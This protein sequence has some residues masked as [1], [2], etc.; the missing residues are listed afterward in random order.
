MKPEVAL[1]CGLEREVIVLQIIS[2]DE[3]LVA[4][5]GSEAM[6]SRGNLLRRCVAAQL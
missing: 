5:A 1:A 6:G 3:Q 2:A 4:A